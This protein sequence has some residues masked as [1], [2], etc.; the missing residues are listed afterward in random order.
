MSAKPTLQKT[1]G[2]RLV[3]ADWNFLLEYAGHHPLDF[4]SRR[5]TFEWGV[6]RDFLSPGRPSWARPQI[7]QKGVWPKQLLVI[8]FLLKVSVC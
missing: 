6:T 4:E 2:N 3:L 8:V 7:L 1:V 5:W